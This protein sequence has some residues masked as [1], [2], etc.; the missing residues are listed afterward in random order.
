MAETSLINRIAIHATA[1]T[2]LPTLATKGSN[3]TQSTWSGASWETLGSRERGSDDGDISDESIEATRERVVEEIMQTRGLQRQ[4]IILLQN[5]ITKFT[6]GVEEASEAIF[7]LASDISV[8]SHEAT[9][10]AALTFRAV[11]IEVSGLWIDYYPKCAVFIDGQVQ[12]YGEGG[13][14]M[15]QL[16]CMPVATTSYPA[17]WSREWYQAA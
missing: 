16:V 12:G 9:H 17:G 7:T 11:A 6:I 2:A 10:A 1:E 15:V 13:K 4:D 3:I 14:G 8:S 5:R